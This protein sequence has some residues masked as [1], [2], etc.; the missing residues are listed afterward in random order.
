MNKSTIKE[1]ICRVISELRDIDSINQPTF[2]SVN[3]ENGVLMDSIEL[4]QLL[5]T[6]ET[7]YKIIFTDDCLD[8][9]K[10]QNID[11]LADVVCNMMAK[12]SEEND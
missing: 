11:F 4:I 5:V 9:D 8:V 7:K 10:L 2:S 1:E 3:N 6:L 12:K